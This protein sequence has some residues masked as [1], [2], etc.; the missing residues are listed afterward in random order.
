MGRIK[1]IVWS[2]VLGAAVLSGA[3]NG[4]GART[5]RAERR[6]ADSRSM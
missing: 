4:E 2:T 6:A 1:N 3:I 5:I